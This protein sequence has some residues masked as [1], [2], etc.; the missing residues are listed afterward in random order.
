M[1]A[2]TGGGDGEMIK[3]QNKLRKLGVE[4]IVEIRKWVKVD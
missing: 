4:A 2:V 3:V 1:M